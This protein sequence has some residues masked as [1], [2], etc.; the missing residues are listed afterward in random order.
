[1]TSYLCSRS[2]AVVAYREMQGT[3]GGTG[4]EC[5]KGPHALDFVASPAE[6]IVRFPPKGRKV[7]QLD[8]CV[9]VLQQNLTQERWPV[10]HRYRY[11]ATDR[12]E[13][14]EQ[15]RPPLTP[16]LVPVNEPRK[17]SKLRADHRR[18]RPV[19]TGKPFFL[20]HFPEVLKAAGYRPMAQDGLNFADGL[21]VGIHRHGERV[22]HGVVMG[23]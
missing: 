9:G 21:M 7:A 6:F 20:V 22:P 12:I 14:I 13:H 15:S 2:I 18:H 4:E 19:A 11:R 5:G 1:V 16:P 23:F 8:L 3:G 17:L 10:L